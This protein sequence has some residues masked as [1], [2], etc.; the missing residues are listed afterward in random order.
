MKKL[1]ALSGAKGA[2]RSRN[3]RSIHGSIVRMSLSATQPRGRFD[4]FAPDDDVG[5][6]NLPS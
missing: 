3:A 1:R 2:V 4:F 5:I 6:A